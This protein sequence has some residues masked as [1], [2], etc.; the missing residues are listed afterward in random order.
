M[1]ASMAWNSMEFL[2]KNLVTSD[3]DKIGQASPLFTP[4][5]RKNKFQANM[6][7]E[8]KTLLKVEFGLIL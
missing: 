8:F 4:F 3:F 2:W 6:D 5:S 7:Q 1:E